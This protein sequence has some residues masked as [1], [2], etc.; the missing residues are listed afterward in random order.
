MLPELMLMELSGIFFT[1][2]PSRKRFAPL[3]RHA[4]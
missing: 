1:S 3:R 4:L 2:S